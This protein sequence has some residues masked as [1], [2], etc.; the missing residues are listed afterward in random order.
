LHNQ[1]LDHALVVIVDE[2]ADLAD[3][4]TRKS[5]ARTA[6]YDQLRRV[7]QLGRSR[8]VHLILCTQRP[9]ADLVPTSIRTLMNARVALHVNDATAS[10]M[11][12]DDAG[13]EQLQ[14]H[15]DLLYKEDG[16]VTRAQG[17]FVGTDDLDRLIGPL[18]FV[19]SSRGLA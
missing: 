2:F 5:A 14:G 11:I 19:S 16:V 3:Q 6:F 18:R 17:Y 10:R 9:S 1:P 12:L 13:A 8:G 4:L 7:A 15:G